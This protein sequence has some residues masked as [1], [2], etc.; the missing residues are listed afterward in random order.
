MTDM[1]I[2]IMGAGGRMG[3]TLTRVVQSVDGCVV[4]GGS[5]APGSPLVGMDIG[6]VAGIEPAGEIITDKPLELFTKID[7]IL[8]FT[9]PATS[10]MFAELAAQARI[11][12]VIGTTGFN[13]GD[14]AKLKAAARHA[15]VIKAGN[16]SLG[17]NLLTAL[18]KKV[19]GA[20]DSSFDI[21]I[22]D[23]HHR[24]KVDAPSGTALMLGGGCRR[25]P[26]YKSRRA[27]S[28]FP[29]RPYRRTSQG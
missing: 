29:P 3:K 26:Q 20:L 6:E 12:H 8:D 27:R 28:I 19:A 13:A 15:V 2:A 17:V 22:V 9:S 14:S 1:K 11:V 24:H 23:M 25:N 21:E 7:A 4:A 5:E 16:M 18:T 10:L